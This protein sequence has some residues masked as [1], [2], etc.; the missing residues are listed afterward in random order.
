MHTLAI[1]LKSSWHGWV[2]SI[3][4]TSEARRK[5]IAEI[6]GFFILIIALF[7]MG[8]AVFRAAE[9]QL[10]DAYGRT[11][12]QAINIFMTLGVFILAKDAMEGSLKQL[13]EA[14]DTSLL[15]SSPLPPSTVFGFK[16]IQ[17]I[18]S[19][20]PSMLIWLFP[21]WIAF[22]R[23]FHLPWHFYVA[24][25]PT[26]F[27]LLVVIM[28]EISIIMMLIVRF[29]SS[30]RMIQF[31]KILGTTIGVAAGLLLAMSFL[32]L[33]KSDQI[34]QF[35]LT[36]LK[37][38]ASDWYPHVWAAKLMMSW[39]PESG[40][41]P[42]RWAG[43]LIGASAGVPVLATILASKIYPRSWEYARRV[44][45]GAKRK[46]KK[47]V[48]FSLV[49]RGK[50]RSMMTKDFLVFVRNK[51]RVTMIVMLTLIILM[52]MFGITYEMR[53]NGGQDT[54]PLFGLTVQI[55]VYSVMITLG[56][57]WGGFKSESKTWWLLKSGPISPE[58]LFKGK[59]LIATL[60]AIVYANVWILLGLILFQIPIWL[61]LP[62]LSGTTIITAAAIAFNTAIGTL[63][64]V[65]EMGK[66]DWD[67]GKRPVL[68]L[69][70]IL[71]TMVLNGVILIVPTVTL[72]F[73]VLN[74][75]LDDMKAGILGH[76]SISLWQQITIV[77]IL[78]MMIGVWGA[79]YLLGKRS[80]RKL[81]E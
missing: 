81:L 61:W 36:R 62:M 50:I 20:V 7:L 78:C 75:L 30:R 67:S 21:P 16:L 65:A 9:T 17:L 63:P 25:I 19:N 32:A 34:A 48:E 45:V 10:G 73:F 72:E 66:T 57:T 1:L 56:L 52:V 24:L 53:K 12:L 79:S 47:V 60:C 77:A 22:G 43:Q 31:L 69:A 46:Q 15:L 68:R 6:I 23:L 4:Y 2:N 26:C 29:F 44:E 27:C 35:I 42:L 39:L 59:F 55:M 49:G 64:W 8:R 51:G 37:A 14:P 33:D 41:H 18:A 54:N 74:D 76:V 11:I 70:T 58:V 71:L 28:G 5:K 40:E 80:L 38:P 3:R 13:Y